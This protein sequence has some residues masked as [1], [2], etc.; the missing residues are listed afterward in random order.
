MKNA[1]LIC[2]IAL[3][4]AVA[5]GCGTEEAGSAATPGT[6][7]TGGS[8]TGATG[9]AGA[10]GGT[11]G[12]AGACT[13]EA[14]QAVYAATEYSNDD[15]DFTGTE[16]VSEIA[17]D[18]VFGTAPNLISDGCGPEVGLV[19]GNNTQENRDALAACVVQCTV[20]QGVDL[21]DECLACYGD[22]VACGAAFCAPECAGGT[23]LPACVDCR[24]GNNDNNT[25]CF[26]DFDACSGLPS[27]GSCG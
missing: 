5:I 13:N 8:G 4:G 1:R 27:S 7:A 16:A 9:G 22:T 12:V 10:T 3:A 23:D 6:G 25:S 20:D 19:L 24:C 2:M 18:C 21:S 17:A 26:G 11:G 15:G 14:D